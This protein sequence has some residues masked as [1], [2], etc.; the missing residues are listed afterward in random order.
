MIG[1]D[2]SLKH[3]LTL[4][5]LICLLLLPVTNSAQTRRRTTTNRRRAAAASSAA[6]SRRNTK[7]LN[8][9]RTR[10]SDQIKLLTR[11]L[12]LFGRISN[13]IEV[14]DAQARGGG[15]T[16]EAAGAQNR[17]K[18]ALRQNLANLRQGLDELEVYFRT[19]PGLERYYTRLAGVAASAEQ[20]EQRA[21]ASQLDQ[22][23]RALLDAV[24][25]LTDVL[26]EMR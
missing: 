2:N 11:F 6:S 9:A 14:A 4:F 1:G 16:P 15:L 24:N 8:A 12:Y 17:N 21:A 5:A 26:G 23:G 20:A 25:R 10:V 18:A 13:G 19:T 3:P 22:A 7:A